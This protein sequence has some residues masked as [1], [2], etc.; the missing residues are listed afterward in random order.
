[1]KIQTPEFLKIPSLVLYF[2]TSFKIQ[3]EKYTVDKR[4]DYYLTCYRSSWLFG[5]HM[6]GT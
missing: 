5:I 2:Y 1:M 3:T 6:T 4:N